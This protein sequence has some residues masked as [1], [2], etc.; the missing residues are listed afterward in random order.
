MFYTML[1]FISISI[2]AV[3]V[4]ILMAISPLCGGY[5]NASVYVCEYFQPVSTIATALLF[6]YFN[7]L[8][9]RTAIGR[10]SYITAF[11]LVLIVIL[12]IGIIYHCSCQLFDRLHAYEGMNNRQIFDFVVDKL[13]AMGSGISGYISIGHQT[14]GKGYIVANIVTYILPM[15]S[16]LCGGAVGKLI[17]KF[18]LK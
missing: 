7:S 4:L 17:S 13:Q 9:I 5:V 2:Y 12:Y 16:V 1:I 8:Y 10:E 14:I 6:F 11:F 18:L 3:C 15:L